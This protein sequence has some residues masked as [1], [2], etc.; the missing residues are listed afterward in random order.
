MRDETKHIPVL[1]KEVIE[2]LKPKKGEKY[3]DAALGFGGYALELVGKGSKV[4]GIELD[5]EVLKLAKKRFFGFCPKASWKLISGN[6]AEIEKIASENDFC[7]V[8]GIIFD[9]GI[10]RWHYK[11]AGRGFSFKDQEL[12]M[13][14]SPHLVIRASDIVNNYSYDQ[15]YR[16][17]TKIA[18]EK[19]AG[20]IA[21]ALVRARR[22]KKIESANQ[23]ADL[24]MGVYLKHRVRTRLHPATKVFLALRTIV[25][26]E[27]E[28]LK[29]GLGGAI[30]ILKT[31]GKLLVITFNSN[32]DRIT[33]KFYRTKE[34]QGLIKTLK[35]VFPTKKEIR[36]NPLARS[37]KLR[38]AVKT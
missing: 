28:N 27:L 13:R 18:Q 10:S 11:Q 15:F 36:I 16:V 32:E 37:A 33:K 30:K 2:T 9:L 7:P 21:R 38:I 31:K 25:N 22:L 19:L 6:F 4:L 24:V 34:K 1:L 8:E 5:P 12:D 14:L 20:P 3:I 23:L 35:L 17:F 26:Q 29:S